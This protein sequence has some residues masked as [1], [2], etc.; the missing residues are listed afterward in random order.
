MSTRKVVATFRNAFIVQEGG[1]F[2]AFNK[3]DYITQNRNA[4]AIAHS[5]QP[6]VEL[7]IE[8]LKSI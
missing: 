7:V 3:K 5:E 6:T 4:T 8:V 1:I 2:K